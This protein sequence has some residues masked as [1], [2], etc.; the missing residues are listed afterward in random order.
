VSDGDEVAAGTDPHVTD[1]P[2]ALPALR[3]LG[4]LVLLAATAVGVAR[5]TGGKIG[6]PVIAWRPDR[7]RVRFRESLAF[8]HLHRALPPSGQN[9]TLALDGDLELVQWLDR[10]G[11]DEAWIGEHHSGGFECIASPELFIAAAAQVT[12]H[13]RL[14]TGVTS[15]P[16]HHPLHVAD[17]WVQ[18][19]HMTRSRCMFGAGSSRWPGTRSA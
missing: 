12:K 5:R 17:R 18:L 14:G 7:R 15:I 9:P 19:D 2:V 4:L 16:D 13:I 8:R 10:L 3:P 1:A 6:K 11:F